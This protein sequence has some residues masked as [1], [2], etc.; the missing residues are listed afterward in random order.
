MNAD[1]AELHLV[2]VDVVLKGPEQQLGVLRGHDDACVD[3]GLGNAGEA[4][5]ERY[6]YPSAPISWAAT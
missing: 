6:Y 4:D 1:F 2:L 3:L 5:V